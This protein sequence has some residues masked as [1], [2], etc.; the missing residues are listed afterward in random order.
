MDAL[1]TILLAITTGLYAVILDRFGHL[2][3]DWVE[4]EVVVGTA[5]VLAFH[6]WRVS[7]H[8]DWT[9]WKGF[10]ALLFDFSAG[11][12]PIVIWYRWR[13]THNYKKTLGGAVRRRQQQTP[14]ALDEEGEE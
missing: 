5:I 1:I 8:A 4:A 14:S 3:A 2:W 6:G 13:T 10:E 12:A 7:H 9:A 11:G